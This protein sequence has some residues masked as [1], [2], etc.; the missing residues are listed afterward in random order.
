MITRLEFERLPKFAHFGGYKLGIIVEKDCIRIYD[1]QTDKEDKLDRDI[2][3]A[4]KQFNLLCICLD[5]DPTK[6]YAFTHN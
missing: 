3:K 5:L 2:K 4:W 6:P 1:Y